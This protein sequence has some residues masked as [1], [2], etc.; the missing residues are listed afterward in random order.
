[1]RLCP[2]GHKVDSETAMFCPVCGAAMEDAPEVEKEPKKRR[3]Y[4]YVAIPL[5]GLLFLCVIIA[6]TTDGG[7]DAVEQ[8]A[9]SPTELVP[10][11]VATSVPAPTDA[12]TLTVVSGPAATSVPVATAV[13]TNTSAPTATPEPTATVRPTRTPEPTEPPPPL[14]Y[15][16]VIDNHDNMTDAQWSLYRE[17]LPGRRVTWQGWIDEVDEKGDVLVDMDPPD[18]LFSVFDVR[19]DIPVADILEYNKDEKVTFEGTVDSVVS[20]LGKLVFNLEPCTILSSE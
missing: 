17:T 18:T 2:N 10:T 19:F 4:L 6:L 15:A 7:D 14:V 11:D 16:E 1:M 20:I 9:S 13:P 12:P 8:I 5:A 3:W